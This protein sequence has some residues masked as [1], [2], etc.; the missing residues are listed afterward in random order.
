M[1]QAKEWKWVD[2]STWD[3]GPW[4]NEP[5]KAQ[6]EDEATGLP[7]LIVRGPVGALCGYVGVGRKHPKYGRDYSEVDAEVHGGLTFADGCQKA[8]PE[9]GICHIV[10]PGEEDDVW[11]FGF[12]CAH[13]WDLAPG[14][15][16]RLPKT[17]AAKLKKIHAKMRISLAPFGKNYRTYAY[18]KAQCAQLAQQL[19]EVQP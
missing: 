18:V 2:K 4:D 16:A 5:D 19:A 10:A 8:D 1:L 17:V 7:C 14:F 9:H 6:W 3:R 13:A 11:W 12:D 15:Y